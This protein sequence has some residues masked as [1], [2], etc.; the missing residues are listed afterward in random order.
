MCRPAGASAVLKR[1]RGGPGRYVFDRDGRPS[2][3]ELRGKDYNKAPVDERF[4][5]QNGIAR[6][7]SGAEVIDGAGKSL[8]PGL[9]DMHVHRDT[10]DGLL[11]IA[12]G[13]TSVRDLG[14]DM[15][16][17][18][19]AFEGQ[20]T[21]RPGVASPSYAAVLERL[22]VQMR[23][24]GV[25]LVIGT[26]GVQGLMLQRDLELWVPAGI[27]AADVLRMA[28]LGAARVARGPGR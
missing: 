10:A 24:A 23:R 20:Y 13:V 25:P 2:A 11:D 26:D 22:P 3:I 12:C 18:L 4:A 15:D 1:P 28:T 27:P 17:T 5:V 21:A 7:K 8:L 16:A 9:F 6:W 19:G 14:N